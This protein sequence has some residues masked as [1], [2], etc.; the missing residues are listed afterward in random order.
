VNRLAPLLLL[1]CAGCVVPAWNPPKPVQPDIVP[2][3]LV[4]S[5]SEAAATGMAEY[6]RQSAAAFTSLA[7]DLRA[8]KFAT[9]LEFAEEMERRTKQ[10][11]VNAFEA[12]REAWQRDNP[13]DHWNMTADAA[14]CEE[15]AKGFER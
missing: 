15:T 6:R 11:R 5:I 8:E 7:E 10:A 14:K 1:L 2:Q 3:P 12:L 9:Q 13:N 4:Q